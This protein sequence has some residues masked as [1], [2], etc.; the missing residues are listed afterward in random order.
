ML[1]YAQLN[2][3]KTQ[4]SKEFADL[5]THASGVIKRNSKHSHMMYTACKQKMPNNTS[6]NTYFHM[7]SFY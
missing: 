6:E 5:Y 7:I 2:D 4:N 3:D 1:I